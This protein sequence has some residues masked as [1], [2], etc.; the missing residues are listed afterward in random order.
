M[1][2]DHKSTQS[3]PLPPDAEA[4]GDIAP[5]NFRAA[6][7]QAADLAA[8]YLEGIHKYRVVPQMQ[9][10]DLR[11]ALPASAPEQGEALE[12]IL[13][14]FTDEIVPRT[15]HW[16]HPGFMAYFAVTGSGPGIIG[17]TLAATLNVNAMLWR[18]GPAPT[19]L[20]EHTCDWLR[21]M[22]GLPEGYVGHIND[23]ASI[24]SFISLAAA[25]ERQRDL[26]IRRKGL[27]GRDV[28]ALTVYCSDQAHSSIDKAVV[29]LGLGLENL[30][31]IETDNAF[32]MDVA[33]LERAIAEDKAAGRRPIAI[34]GTFGTTSTTSMDPLNEL[35]QI[36]KREDLWF[37]VDGAYA[38]M[39]GI[40]PEYR[41]LMRGLELADSIV[42]NPHKWLFVPV[43]CS[44]LFV[45]DPDLLRTAFSIVPDYLTTTET[46]VTNLMDYGVQLGRR[47]RALK[48]WLVLRAFG[49]A[50]LQE[51]IRY[52]CHLAQRF[53]AWVDAEPYLER[54]APVPYST[55]CFR[56][57]PPNGASAEA[58]DAFNEQLLTRVNAAGPVF[59]SHTRLK[60]RFVMR[61]SIG[62]LRTRQI[63]VDDVQRLLRE[64][65]QA[66]TADQTPA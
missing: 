12:T 9:P 54:I 11:R 10:G 46:N 40:C 28:P 50:G 26:D 37:H 35:G 58:Q 17:E 36:A 4:P 53:A 49:V 16:N 51:R 27:A 1:S 15:T 59:V 47:F 44:V 29:A 6:M 62:N 18:T 42:T 63:H 39:A 20:E 22:L 24:G 64:H 13:R 34:V 25:R 23:T 3:S 31:R 65:Y 5:E 19:E 66:L 30:R 33:K 8:D 55:V 57:L 14:D 45:R 2:T 61:V 43:D 52:H 7:H 38:L 48:L 41:P 21:Q 60:G 56:A 32:R